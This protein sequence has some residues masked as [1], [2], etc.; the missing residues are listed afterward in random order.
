MDPKSTKQQNWSPCLAYRFKLTGG[1]EV[2]YWQ[3][4]NLCKFQ[5]LQEKRNSP[6]LQVQVK[7]GIV[8]FLGLVQDSKKIEAYKVHSKILDENF[9]TEV[10]F[11]N[12]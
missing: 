11:V 6:N 4:K 1:K 12:L 8:S 7:S 2:T 10:N 9:Q 5:K 3:A